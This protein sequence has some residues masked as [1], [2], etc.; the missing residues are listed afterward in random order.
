MNLADAIRKAAQEGSLPP[1]GS[2]PTA[3]APSPNHNVPESGDAT[4]GQGLP[5]D[6]PSAAI[7]SGNV[8]RIELFLSSEQTSSMLRA[9]MAGQHTVM[10]MAEA[11]QYLRIRPQ[12]LAKLARDGEI[13][14]VEIDGR[15]RFQKH[16]LDEWLHQAVTAEEKT[17]VA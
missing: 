16:V 9:I 15:Y 6:A 14:S 2:V 17:D 7:L 10:T 4:V 1:I 3:F 5:P 12:S 8:V 11:A 13:P